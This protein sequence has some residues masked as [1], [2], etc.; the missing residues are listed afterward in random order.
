MMKKPMQPV[1]YPIQPFGQCLKQIL[2]EKKVSASELAKVMEYKSRNSVFRILDGVGGYS[3]CEAFFEKLKGNNPLSWGEAEFAA[4]SQALE[5]TRVGERAFM[6]NCAMREMLMNDG[7]EPEE[8]RVCVRAFNT[9]E[10][11]DFQQTLEIMARGRRAHLTITGCCDR[12]IFDALRER[13][14]KTDIACD[15]QIRHI[16]YTGAEEIVRNISAIQPL[17]YTDVYTAY[18]LEPGMFSRERESMLRVNC[19]HLHTQDE[20]GQW[21]NQMLVLVDKGV[22]LAIKR[23]KGTEIDPY[24]KY[25]KEDMAR[26]PLLKTDF[27]KMGR[28]EDY[29]AY[30]EDCRKL[31]HNRTIYTIKPDVP[32]QYIHPDILLPCAREGLADMGKADPEGFERLLAQMEQ[33]HLARWENI[34]C[35]KKAKHTIFSREAMEAFARTGRQSDHF[36]AIRPYTNAE[37]VAILTHLRWQAEKNPDFHVYFFKDDCAAPRTE[38]GLYDGVGTLMTKPD[39]HYNLAADHAETVITQAEFCERYKEFYVRDLLAKHVVSPEE[40]LDILDR[41]IETAQSE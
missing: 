24:E 11:P 25:L 19:I 17:L 36:F 20:R 37:R 14:Y 5:V 18:C 35:R 41:L 28:L 10:D 12:A 26:M 1:L 31:E 39:T 30:I 38:I 21:Y 16:V 8:K 4:L 27:S 2:G 22:F 6:S 34:F 15:V 33:I 40:T 32:L 3:V 7:A 29:L 23:S 9:S 13:I